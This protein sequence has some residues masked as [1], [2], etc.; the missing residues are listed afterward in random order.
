MNQLLEFATNHLLLV[1]AAA[2]TGALLLYNEIRMAGS[3]RY[4]VSPDQAVRLMNKGALVLDLR[5]PEEY[6][7]GHL[8]GAKNL[9][10]V[11]FDKQIDS[12]KRFR[13]KPV[14]AYDERGANMPR[15]IAHLRR[16]EFEHVFSLRGGL[17][18]WREEH[19]PLEKAGKK[20]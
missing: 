6:A 14:I 7:T 5:K 8:S 1:A 15:A 10:L 9:Q 4:A 19:L 12:L 16:A 3:S 13:N 18:A 11:D 17:L 2:V 20:S